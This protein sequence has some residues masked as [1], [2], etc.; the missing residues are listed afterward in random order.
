MVG[1]HVMRLPDCRVSYRGTRFNNQSKEYIDNSSASLNKA[2]AGDFVE[3]DM[4]D[5]DVA[6]LELLNAQRASKD[7]RAR[8]V[9]PETFEAAI[10]RLE[11]EGFTLGVAIGSTTDTPYDDDAVCSICMSGECDNSNAILFCDACNVPVHQE[12]YGV[13]FVPEG[14]WLCRLCTIAP[15]RGGVSCALCPLIGGA[16]KQTEDGRSW[17][18]VQCALWLPEIDFGS[19]QLREPIF[20]LKKVDKER[21]KFKCYLC[22]RKNVGACIQCYRKN[23]YTAYHVTCAQE[24]GLCMHLGATLEG[25]NSTLETYCHQHT[26]RWA[27]QSPLVR[28]RLSAHRCCRVVASLHA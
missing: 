4:D 6:W 16:L 28:Y 10:D 21:F 5:E 11:K 13:P 8:P 7:R 26:P 18:H 15:S 12:C 19:L 23:C 3:Y 25:E 2:S 27:A 9:R 24:A 14:Q 1:C 20:G 17:V 22:G